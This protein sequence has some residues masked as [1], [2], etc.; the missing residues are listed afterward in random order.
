MRNHAKNINNP[1]T[2]IAD[3]MPDTYYMP[4]IYCPPFWIV[5]AHI[6]AILFSIGMIWDILLTLSQRSLSSV[7]P[8]TYFFFLAFV[9]VIILS[10]FVIIEMLFPK[11]CLLP[12][13]N[14]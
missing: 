14:L 2:T 5:L 7:S 9:A 4:D 12:P 1:D 10:G 11:Q 13:P 6:F 3:C 8:M